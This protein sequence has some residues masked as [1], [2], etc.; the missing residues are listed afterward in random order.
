MGFIIYQK[1]NNG[2]AVSSRGMTSPTAFP[3]HPT[4]M[5][6]T[7][8]MSSSL[9]EYEEMVAE[10]KK[11]TWMHPGCTCAG[12][13][14]LAWLTLRLAFKIGLAPLGQGLASSA[15]AQAAQERA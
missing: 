1:N 5:S 9:L 15:G 12:Q 13:A 14:T 6:V 7:S 2:E 3:Q 10:T 11:K 8:A 4:A